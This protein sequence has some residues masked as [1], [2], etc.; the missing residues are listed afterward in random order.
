M[1]A[2]RRIITGRGKGNVDTF[3]RVEDV[4]PVMTHISW[5]PIWGWD[6]WPRL[7]IAESDQGVPSTSFPPPEAPQ[8]VRI[9]IVDFA[10]GEVVDKSRVAQG[11]AQLGRFSSYAESGMHA[12][13]SV[14]VVIVISGTIRLTMADGSS[15]LLRSADVVVQN[16]G[17]H[18]WRNEGDG[19]C[20]L[21]FVIFGA[22]THVD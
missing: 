16:A 8:G 5:H 19:P 17:V 4:Q 20:R 15:Q 11:S 3:L 10:P 7:P 22:E 21:A 2:V 1:N 18:A 9:S 6:S 13:T 14:D 12:T